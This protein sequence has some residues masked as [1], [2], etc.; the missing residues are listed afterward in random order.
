MHDVAQHCV[1]QC[2]LAGD[3]C[4]VVRFQVEVEQLWLVKVVAPSLFSFMGGVSSL[5]YETKQLQDEDPNC[6]ASEVAPSSAGVPRVVMIG[7][8]GHGKSRLVQKIAGVGSLDSTASTSATAHSSSYLSAC[9]SLEVIDT[10][11]TDSLGDT[12]DDTMTSR[13]ELASGPERGL[14]DYDP[15]CC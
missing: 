7:P 5:F 11:G 2:D 6:Y 14:C 12:V 9:G 8:C 3:V 4:A 15:L 10:P 1:I 13:M